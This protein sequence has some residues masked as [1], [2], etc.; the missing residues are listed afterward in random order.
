MLSYEKFVEIAKEIAADDC[1]LH[2]FENLEEVN[3]ESETYDL[4]TFVGTIIDKINN[5]LEEDEGGLC[6]VWLDYGD[7]RSCSGN[8]YV[9]KYDQTVVLD[10]WN[11]VNFG[12]TLKDF[13]DT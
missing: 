8:M 1:R 10:F 4:D 7:N 9:T 5:D 6:G 11:D 12:E 2:R 3:I 13:Y